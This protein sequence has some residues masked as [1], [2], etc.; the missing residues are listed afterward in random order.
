MIKAFR[1]IRLYYEAAGLW[2]DLR[3]DPWMNLSWD[4]PQL[5]EHLISGV[6]LFFFGT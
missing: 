1:A 3:T 4:A 6:S 2:N 5:G